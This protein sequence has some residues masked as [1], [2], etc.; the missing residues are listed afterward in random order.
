MHTWAIFSICLQR[1]SVYI[2]AIEKHCS[3]PHNDYVFSL[4]ALNKVQ[5]DVYGKHHLTLL[6]V[7]SNYVIKDTLCLR[8][9]II[10]CQWSL[11][12]HQL[13]V[14]ITSFSYGHPKVGLNNPHVTHVQPSFCSQAIITWWYS[15]SSMHFMHS[16]KT[17][18]CS[19]QVQL[20]SFV[21]LNF[22]I[23]PGF[24]LVIWMYYPGSNVGSNWFEVTIW[25]GCKCTNMHCTLIMLEILHI[26]L[27]FIAQ[28]FAF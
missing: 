7:S 26:M 22:W 16:F 21:G 8:C 20:Y 4:G 15:L 23:Q 6:D 1:L 24:N 10:R 3:N 14:Y 25:K 13:F 19:T 27:C 11:A 18:A 5:S 2:Q 28:K 9:K 17:A 12:T